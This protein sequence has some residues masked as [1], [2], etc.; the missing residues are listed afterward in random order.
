MGKHGRRPQQDPTNQRR[1][2]GARGLAPGTPVQRLKE[3]MRGGRLFILLQ[4]PFQGF[5]LWRALSDLFPHPP[6][7]DK[8]SKRAEHLDSSARLG[9]FAPADTLCTP[10]RSQFPALPLPVR[11]YRAF[12]PRDNFY[13]KGTAGCVPCPRT[14]SGQLAPYT[15]TCV[16]LAASM[17]PSP[18]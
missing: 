6:N 5:V 2:V 7:R 17:L 11:S 1:T 18:G 13:T 8:T 15:G 12:P 4:S 3:Q 10:H 14:L 9:G 16:T